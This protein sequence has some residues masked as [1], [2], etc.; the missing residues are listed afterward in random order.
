MLAFLQWLIKAVESS[1]ELGWQFLREIA[2]VRDRLRE[3]FADGGPTFATIA[4]E[5]SV[6]MLIG[7]DLQL[8]QRAMHTPGILRY[9][10]NAGFDPVFCGAR[11]IAG[12]L[13]EFT[14]SSPLA[15][16]LLF[17]PPTQI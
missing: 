4:A 1:V 3:S 5:Q 10:R 11:E 9:L 2:P 6:S 12:E 14:C 17:E 15:R 8:L 7:P 13:M 16:E